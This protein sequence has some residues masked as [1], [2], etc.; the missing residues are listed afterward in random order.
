M[1]RP[2]LEPPAGTGPHM[3]PPVEVRGAADPV[4][5][6]QLELEHS[7]LAQ[8]LYG[9]ENSPDVGFVR[10]AVGC[11]GPTGREAAGI[12]TAIAEIWTRYL[13]VRD[14]AQQLV[15][16]ATR[17]PGVVERLWRPGAVTLP[18]GRTTTV[19]AL[20]V[21]LQRQVDDAA[22]SAT[23]LASRARRAMASLDAVTATFVD[24][25]ERA[26][27]LGA[28]HD[29]EIAEARRRLERA[30]AAAADEPTAGPPT[31]LAEAVETARRRVEQL[32]RQ[33]VTLPVDLA[34]AH[35]QLDEIRRLVTSGA[36]ATTEARDKVGGSAVLCEPLDPA[37][38]D[39][40][41]RALQPWLAQLEAQASAGRWPA[42]AAGLE[43][44]QQLATSW[45]AGARHVLATNRSPV[46]RRN[47]LRGLLAACQAR[48]AAAG[49]AED[50]E[51]VDLGGIADDELHRAPCD[52]EQAEAR[53]HAYAAVLRAGPKANRP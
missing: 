38:L 52:L 45:L 20:L 32:E 28:E 43:Q 35:A 50:P 9:L 34:T 16:A 17:R 7:H 42:A 6:G 18:R 47:E 49:R 15:T 26:A 10:A 8:S 11:G 27:A 2:P 39:R 36:E 37:G 4:P 12:A 1:A 40:G 25:V 24:L 41:E 19:R 33:R 46:V 14:R 48:A 31:Q 23:R 29:V 44:W 5:A 3:R 13:P 30:V 51:L 21:D 22:A 53:V